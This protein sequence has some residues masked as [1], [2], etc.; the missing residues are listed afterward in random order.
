MKSMI[1]A[2]LAF[3]AISFAPQ[4]RQSLDPSELEVSVANSSKSVR[5]AEDDNVTLEFTSPA[6]RSMNIE[7]VH[8][9]YIGN[10]QT[11]N[12]AP[13]FTSCQMSADPVFHADKPRRVTLFK[14]SDMWLTG[15]TFP[16][17]WR[18]ANT[19]VRVGD[20]VENGLQLVQLWV[21]RRDRPEE[22]LVVYPPDGNWRARPL[23]YGNMR[24]T[25]YG[26]S[27]L[28]GPI[29]TQGRPMVDLESIDFDPPTRTF[30][31]KFVRGG[32]AKIRVVSTESTGTSLDVSYSDAMP[33][34]RPFAA[35]RSMYVSESYAD[36]ARVEWRTK[37]A[38]GKSSIMTWN[39][40]NVRELWA[41]RVTPSSHNLSAPDMVFGKFSATAALQ[42]ATAMKPS[43][44]YVN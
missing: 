12:F 1:L 42:E 5:C 10:I 24:W 20:H 39:G 28:V 7:A 6:V 33:A 8:P 34:G 27:F 9:A 36:V 18:P 4:A 41:G 29:E 13:N 21:R 16:S 35:I 17:F 32:S 30:T 15:Y 38:W 11:D 26:S 3:M 40:G 25:A 43:G 22:V 14:T 44:S 31:L 19:P 2:T 37:G 23:A